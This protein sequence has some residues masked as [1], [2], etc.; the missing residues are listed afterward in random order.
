[1][2]EGKDLPSNFLASVDSPNVS[3]NAESMERYKRRKNDL[4]NLKMNLKL[5]WCV[6]LFESEHVEV[7]KMISVSA[8][9]FDLIFVKRKNLDKSQFFITLRINVELKHQSSLLFLFSLKLDIKNQDLDLKDFQKY[10]FQ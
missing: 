3:L 4:S 6:S 7:T 5:F 2:D 1:M 10:Q 9:I 8:N